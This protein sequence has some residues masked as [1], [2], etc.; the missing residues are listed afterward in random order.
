MIAEEKQ[1]RGCE[2]C[3]RHDL[4]L[5]SLHFHH[6]TTQVQAKKAKVC[7]MFFSTASAVRAEMAKCTVLCGVTHHHYHRTGQLV[8]CEILK[9]SAVQK[10]GCG[11]EL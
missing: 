5:L 2:I 4:P 11:H 1:R 6:L 9:Q 10:G 3:K 7:R 8:H